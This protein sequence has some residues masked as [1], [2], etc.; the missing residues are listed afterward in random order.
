MK[1]KLIALLGL[2]GLA[3][4]GLVSSAAADVSQRIPGVI[5]VFLTGLVYS[6]ADPGGV[7]GCTVSCDGYTY[8]ATYFFDYI[9]DDFFGVG[10][11]QIGLEVGVQRMV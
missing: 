6:S 7:F 8:T 4:V 9:A 10:E 11:S 1:T 5:A 3:L 2:S